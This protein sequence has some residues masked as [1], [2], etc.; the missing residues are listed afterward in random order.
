MGPG[1]RQITSVLTMDPVIVF[2]KNWAHT[3]ICVWDVAAAH[4]A[5][6]DAL[7]GRPEEV[8]GE[9]FL[10]TGNGPAWTLKDTRNTVKVRHYIFL[11]ATRYIALPRQAISSFIL[12]PHNRLRHSITVPAL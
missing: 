3:N 5:L 8:G 1:D 12:T 2:D 10:I 9:A 6:E 7:S 4:L 11:F